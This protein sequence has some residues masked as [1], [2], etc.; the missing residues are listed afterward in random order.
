MVERDSAANAAS[1]LEADEL[2]WAFE[3]RAFVASERARLANL[4]D[5][6]ADDRDDL[7]G[8]RER[9]ADGREGTARRREEFAAQRDADATG[10]AA[11]LDR[12]TDRARRDL[13]E[14]RETG[15]RQRAATVETRRRAASDRAA[16][17]RRR[18]EAGVGPEPYG[19]FLVAQFTALTRELFV[20]RDLFAVAERVADLTLECIPGAVATGVTFFEGVRPM[21]HVATD[22]IAEQ[23]GA[24][25]LAR[26]EGPICESLERGAPMSIGDL[27]SDERWPAFRE[28]A[29]TLGVSG[30]AACGLTV[31]RGQR[32]QP[33]GALTVYADR[34]GVFDDDTGDEVS[35]FAAHLALVAAFDW[36]RHDVSRREAALHR[37]LGSRDIIGQAK[38]IL[39]E[40]QHIPAG[41]AFDLLR[42]TSQRLN[43]RLQELAARVAETGELPE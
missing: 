1:G 18:A 11:R 19:S 17:G 20:S 39:M 25:Q 26:D 5:A 42:R 7:A 13:A 15:R 12:S 40:R 2:T 16:S 3:R 28:M 31:Q 21:A 30:V 36:D 38:G 23:L 34:P 9:E 22:D 37:A 14:V 43:V 41:D 10:A 27:A 6:E 35:L 24:Y 8:Q 4:R 29:D 32:W 33:L